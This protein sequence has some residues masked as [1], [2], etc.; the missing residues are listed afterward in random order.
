M[1]LP[2]P[3]Q[4]PPIGE[5]TDPDNVRV[6]AVV[7][8]QLASAPARGFGLTTEELTAVQAAAGGAYQPAGNYPV[9][10]AETRSRIVNGAMQISQE[11]G[12]TL[13]TGNGYWCADQWANTYSHGLCWS[14]HYPSLPTPNGSK[15]RLLF[16]ISTANAAPT[17]W[18][19]T[20]PIEQSRIADFKW[21]TASARQII[22]RFGFQSSIAGTFSFTL[23]N[24]VPDRTYA[25]VFTISAGQ[26]NTDTVQTFVIPGDVTG[27]WSP[28]STAP[29]LYLQISFAGTGAST[30]PATG[31]QAGNYLSGPGGTNG[32]ASTSNQFHVWDVGL[33]LDPLATG[34]APAWT[35]PDEAQELAACMR[36]WEKG[37][38]D[39]AYAVA[40]DSNPYGSRIVFHTVKR[41]IPAVTASGTMS[42][43]LSGAITAV[44]SATID[45][46]TP[47]RTGGGGSAGFSGTIFSSSFT[48]NSRM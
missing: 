23:R 43:T 5:Q 31:W 40:A 41:T 22:L 3:T 42:G 39:G 30:A 45:G 35:M 7:G 44:S 18:F 2:G 26:A 6:A 28:A 25:Q 16:G 27:N 1:P 47:T 46:F 12:D 17:Y 24:S 34:R 9:K 4:I 32:M 14:L 11:N 8:G 38:F 29:G 33:Y 37:V 20:Q 10:T 19:A 13:A 21:G 36:Y 48:A 15:Y